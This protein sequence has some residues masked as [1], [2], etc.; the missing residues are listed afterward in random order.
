[1][2]IIGVVADY[3][4]VSFTEPASPEIFR[5]LAQDAS[6]KMTLV[7]RTKQNAAFV[8][9]ALRNKIAGIDRN[10]PV[11]DVASMSERLQAATAGQRFNAIAAGI[12]GCLS[13]ILAATGIYGIVAYSAGRRMSEIGLRMALGSTRTEVLSLVIRGAMPWIV[14]GLLAGLGLGAISGLF[15]RALLFEV[16]PLQGWVFIA[17][18]AVVVSTS[19]VACLVP[20][21]KAVQTDPLNLLRVK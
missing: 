13:L 5:P 3:K 2:T 11:Y 19:L 20:A 21:I 1:L 12:F 4:N 17:S 16:A 6:D 7:L 9:P 15:M 10:Q 8:V 14:L 18:V